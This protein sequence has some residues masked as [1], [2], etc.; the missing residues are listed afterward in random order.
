VISTSI[1]PLLKQALPEV[2]IGMLVGSWS[3]PVIENHPMLSHVHFV[4][5]WKLNR[6]ALPLRSKVHRYLRTRKRALREIRAVR[7]DAAIELYG[8]F[9]N[10]IPLLWSAGIPLRAG[11]DS[12]GFGRMLTHSLPWTDS[13]RQVI[14]YQIDLL[15][16]LGVNV[17]QDVCPR[18]IL[19]PIAPG[20]SAA[21]GQRTTANNG[22]YIVVHMGAG[23]KVK[24]WPLGCWE[25]LAVEL[26]RRG[27]Q[28]VLTGQGEREVRHSVRVS[29]AVPSALNLTGALQWDEFVAVLHA[30]QLVVCVDS[31]AGHVA[32]AGGVP[33]VVLMAGLDNPHRWLPLG[34]AVWGLTNP[35]SCAPCYRSLGCATMDCIKGIGV[36]RVLA[37]VDSALA[38]SA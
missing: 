38:V 32:A 2:E 23:S 15:K 6:A 26:H 30:A 35:V 4:D 31:A 20:V 22:R 36:E 37:A 12:G 3:R 8:Y 11:Y 28:L 17:G 33:C 29:E 13:D 27:H 14:H 24:E 1:L 10:S 18:P 16:T 21:V 25:R 7:Y 9:P 34:D 19:P 5:H